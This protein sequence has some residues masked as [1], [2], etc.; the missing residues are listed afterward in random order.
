MHIQVSG[1]VFVAVLILLTS[2]SALPAGGDSAKPVRLPALT[3]ADGSA[4]E[5]NAAKGGV[6]VVVFL[7][8]ECPISNGYS[9]TLNQIVAEFAG[10]PV[11]LA[12]IF[13]DAGMSDKDVTAHA[14]EFQLKF[15]VV[16]DPRSATAKQLG[17]TVSPEAFVLDEQGRV[18]YH[19]RIDDQYAARLQRNNR[20]KTREL[21]DAI[22]AVLAGREVANPFVEAVGCPLPERRE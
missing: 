14:R 20:P 9:P 22:A 21:R 10:K 13:V 5:L 6:A 8:P 16:R 18:R 3:A 17:A 2:V 11:R 19:G 15:P 4:V 1:D 7:S 12:G